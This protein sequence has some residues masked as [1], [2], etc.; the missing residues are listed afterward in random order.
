M[1]AAVVAHQRE[2]DM[3]L[4]YT[5]VEFAGV[6]WCMYMLLDWSI[7]CYWPGWSGVIGL[8]GCENGVIALLVE[9]CCWNRS[10]MQGPNKGW[11]MVID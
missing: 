7:D 10:D 3:T 2:V 1:V 5:Y 8:Y 11:M 9:R 4:A 6:V